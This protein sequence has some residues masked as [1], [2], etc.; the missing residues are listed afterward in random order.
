[1]QLQ[2]NIDELVMDR[3]VDILLSKLNS[4]DGITA[5]VVSNGFFKR[6]LTIDIDESTEKLN[7]NAILSLGSMIGTILTANNQ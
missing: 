2:Y 5:R 7:D 6:L 3:V 4:I 1:M